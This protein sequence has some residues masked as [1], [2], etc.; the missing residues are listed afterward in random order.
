MEKLI[1]AAVNKA[2]ATDEG[3][4][5]VKAEHDRHISHWGCHYQGSARVYA[6]VGQ[7][8]AEAM[9]TLMNVKD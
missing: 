9:I 1:T 4:Q 8:L 2:L 3:Y 5:K 6:L 7:G